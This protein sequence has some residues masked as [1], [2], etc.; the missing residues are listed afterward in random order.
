MPGGNKVQKITIIPRG[1]AGGYNLM[2]PEEEKYNRSKAE[3]IAMITSFMGGRVA[4]AIIY[5]N[6]NVS[7]GASDDIAKATKIARKMVTE[8]GMSDLGPI[9]YEED[10]DTPFLGRDYMK[11]VSFSSLTAQEIDTEVRKI[12]LTAEK[13]AHKIISENRQLLELI[14]DALVLNETIVAEEIDYINKY[15]KL[16]PRMDKEKQELSKTYSKEDFEELFN[17]VAGEK[18]IS[19][20][21]FK[22]EFDKDDKK[23]EKP[24]KPKRQKNN[25]EDGEAN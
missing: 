13:N 22:S 10:S 24:D 5:G 16:P 21:K 15:M 25:N 20:D 4:E 17:E 23:S 19:E 1:H 8:W 14:K 6:E 18:K 2:L 9:K 11:N 7:T 3:L 12:M